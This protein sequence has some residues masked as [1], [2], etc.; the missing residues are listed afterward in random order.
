MVTVKAGSDQYD[1]VSAI[2]EKHNP[3]D[4]DERAAQYGSLETTTTARQW[5]H[6]VRRPR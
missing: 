5:E 6:R 2:L 3:I 1:R 4:M